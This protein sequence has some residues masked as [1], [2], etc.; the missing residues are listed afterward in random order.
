MVRPC[1]PSQI[2]IPSRNSGG[3]IANDDTE[4][5]QH[6]L[7]GA[8]I[9]VGSFD[10]ELTADAPLSI[11]TTNASNRV[12]VTADG[13]VEIL[14]GDNV[15]VDN[16]STVTWAAGENTL[17]ITVDGVEYTVIVTK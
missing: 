3:I 14:M 8:S 6:S 9:R 7:G 4:I 1:N 12:T 15:V 5:G 10:Y 13:D 17:T 16:G 2:C 11:S